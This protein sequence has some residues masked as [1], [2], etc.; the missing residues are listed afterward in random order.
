[1]LKYHCG[2]GLL[3]EFTDNI[4]FDE[5]KSGTCMSSSCQ[6]FVATLLHAGENITFEA[7]LD[8]MILTQIVLEFQNTDI[9]L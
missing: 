8:D 3:D 1:M 5:T 9:T 4:N 2:S 7:I 6:R